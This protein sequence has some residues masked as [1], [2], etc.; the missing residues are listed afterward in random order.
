MRLET[1]VVSS[2]SLQGRVVIVNVV[3]RF[4]SFGVFRVV[5]FMSECAWVLG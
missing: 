5:D 1:E 3:A 2:F 4:G